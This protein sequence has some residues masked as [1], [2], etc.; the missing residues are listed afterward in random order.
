MKKVVVTT[1]IVFLLLAVAYFFFKPRY[2]PPVHIVSSLPG[3]YAKKLLSGGNAYLITDVSV[4]PM[5]QDTVLAHQNVIINHGRIVTITAISEPIDS[6]SPPMLID[7]TG[8]F[9]IPGLSD[10]H[11]HINDDTNLLLFVANGVTTVRNMAGYPFHLQLRKRIK[12]QTILGPTL[13]TA[14]PILEGKNKIWPF[15]IA[16][17][18][19]QDAANAVRRYKHEDYDFIKI[20]SV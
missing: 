2:L 1:S 10:M 18:T 8:K 11:V 20:S 9:L 16:L 6:A 12:Q 4:I 19:K 15:S 3:T 13:Y 5:N 14:S 7:G 17:K